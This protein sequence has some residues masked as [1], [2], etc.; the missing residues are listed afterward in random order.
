[1]PKRKT[2]IVAAFTPEAVLKRKIRAHLRKLGFKKAPGGTLL[3]P[4]SAKENVRALHLEQRKALP[5]SQ[6]E[7][8]RRAFPELKKYFAE[9]HDIDP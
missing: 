1:V 9:G 8:I 4:S 5:K 3:P 2:I 6:R 7:F